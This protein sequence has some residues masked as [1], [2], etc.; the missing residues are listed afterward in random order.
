MKKK[1][2]LADHVM[3]RRALISLRPAAA[4]ALR[5]DLYADLDWQDG[6]QI[7]PTLAEVTAEITR[8]TTADNAET[9]RRAS[10]Q[11]DPV[12]VDLLQRLAGATP[13]QI[14][15]YVDNNVN[16]LADAKTMFKRILKLIAL[17]QRS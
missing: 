16:T 3:L 7:K 17:D 14:D 6:V 9:A 2:A 4:F 1:M 10:I 11:T 15:T 12:R 13:A 8:L 5:G